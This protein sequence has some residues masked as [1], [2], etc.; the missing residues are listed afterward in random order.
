MRKY[1]NNE[2][3]KAEELLRKCYNI[4]VEEIGGNCVPIKIIG[5]KTAA[6]KITAEMMNEYNHGLAPKESYEYE[7]FIFWR[8]VHEIL[9]SIR[10]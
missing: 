6:T 4:E 7:R 3:A 8:N 2:K 1:T 9:E 10:N 5:A